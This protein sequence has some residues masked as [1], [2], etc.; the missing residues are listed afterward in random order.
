MFR[1]RNR[2]RIV[3]VHL[4]TMVDV[5]IF[6]CERGC[7]RYQCPELLS[8]RVQADYRY[9]ML[10]GRRLSDGEVSKSGSIRKLDGDVQR[11]TARLAGQQGV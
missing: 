9:G 2:E 10:N 7:R 1:G 6:E 8:R 3:V 11:R 5:V 4:G